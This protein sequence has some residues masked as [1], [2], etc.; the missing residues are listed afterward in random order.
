MLNICIIMGAGASASSGTPLMHNFLDTTR[1]L[2]STK[3]SLSSRSDSLEKIDKFRQNLLASFSKA[4]PDIDNIESLMS[5][6]ELQEAV[7]PHQSPNFNS[8]AEHEKSISSCISEIVASTIDAS[9]V[10]AVENIASV[11]LAAEA[12]YSQDWSI[13]NNQIEIYPSGFYKEFSKFLNQMRSRK[14]T[15]LSVITTNYDMATEFSALYAGMHVSYPGLLHRSLVHNYVSP[16]MPADSRSNFSIYKLHGS[17]NWFKQEGDENDIFI[18]PAVCIRDDILNHARGVLSRRGEIR[19]YS[20]NIE[21]SIQNHSLTQ[22]EFSLSNSAIIPPTQYKMH[23]NHA[24]YRHWSKA[25]HSLQGAD[26]LVIL[27]YSL[28]I[29]DGHFRSLFTLAMLSDKILRHVFIVDP[30]PK[31]HER[32]SSLL[33][34]Y[35]RSHMTA[36]HEELSPQ[37]WRT[38]ARGIS[39]LLPDS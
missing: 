10:Y 14:N 33:G 37:N 13:V 32:W 28:P 38:V 36:I 15:N 2:I 9:Q 18:L 24:I 17:V 4:T 5:L 35:A 25:H 16:N 20:L 30:S 29:S 39:D 12:A 34:E 21:N 23:K 8:K 1:K 22:N 7:S 3:S 27:G 26:V 6:A 19:K 31:T 11:Q